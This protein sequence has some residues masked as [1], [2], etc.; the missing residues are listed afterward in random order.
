V[1][2]VK[3]GIIQVGPVKDQQID[4]FKAQALDGLEVV[5]LAVGDQAAL[6]QQPREDGM[7]SNGPLAGAELGPVKGRGA[8]INGSGIDDFN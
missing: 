2:S 7:Q 4:R 5:G 3:P 1:Q 6:A 8:Q